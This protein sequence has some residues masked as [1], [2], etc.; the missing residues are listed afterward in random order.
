MR[1]QAAAR[2]A[3]TCRQLV[4]PNVVPFYG[5]FREVNQDN[6]AVCLVSALMDDNL[7]DFLQKNL[8]DVQQRK[9]EHVDCVRLVSAFVND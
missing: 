5:V 1:V 7:Y 8:E 2:E 4:H 3:V 9:G 6:S